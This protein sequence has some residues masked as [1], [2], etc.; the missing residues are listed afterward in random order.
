MNN[1]ETYLQSKMVATPY[2]NLE[3]EPETRKYE[4]ETRGPEPETREPEPETRIAEPETRNPRP[5]TLKKELQRT[6]Q[7]WNLNPKLERL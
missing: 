4:P 3:P 2:S 7:T 1:P 5:E 6:I